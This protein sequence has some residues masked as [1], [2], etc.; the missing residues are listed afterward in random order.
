MYTNCSH[1]SSFCCSTIFSV[2]LTRLSCAPAC[3]GAGSSG[4]LSRVNTVSGVRMCVSSQLHLMISV[5]RH[6]QPLIVGV[7]QCG[8]ACDII[9]RPW[10]VFEI[11]ETNTLWFK[12]YLVG[13]GHGQ[14]YIPLRFLGKNNSR[15][16]HE[17]YSSTGKS[18]K[19][20]EQITILNN[21]SD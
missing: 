15:S 5:A 12:I 1:W 11:C 7:V 17:H 13:H 21:F 4:S 16:I 6:H 3:R 9:F 19:K 14:P 2:L 20:Y 18:F 10:R 8:A